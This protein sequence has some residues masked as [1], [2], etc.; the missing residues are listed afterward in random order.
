MREQLAREPPTLDLNNMKVP[1]QR[2]KAVRENHQIH[3]V[4]HQTKKA[5]N[6]YYDPY[7]AWLLRADCD[8]GRCFCIG[9]DTF[10]FRAHFDPPVALLPAIQ[11][12][13]SPAPRDRL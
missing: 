12:G 9:A 1:H 3:A 11:Q 10:N 4:D 7:P 8:G 5:E 6:Q 13:L 2:R